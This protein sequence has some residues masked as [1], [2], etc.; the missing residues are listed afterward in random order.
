MIRFYDL[1]GHIVEYESLSREKIKKVHGM[2]VRCFL[3]D[4][5]VCEGFADAYRQIGFTENN[6]TIGEYIHLWTWDN[7]NEKTHQLCGDSQS[8]YLQTYTPIKIIDIERIDAIMYSNPRFGTLL[9]NKF[10]L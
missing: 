1:N 6:L 9:T 7:L 2:M 3:K 5:T 10:W 4:K 8:K